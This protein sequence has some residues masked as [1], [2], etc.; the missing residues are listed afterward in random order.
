MENQ[1]QT[2]KAKSDRLGVRLND[3]P[4][5]G[6]EALGAIFQ[7]GAVKY[8][9]GNWKG[10]LGD[11]TYQEERLNHAIRHLMLWA[12]GDRSE[13]HLAKVAWFC[14]TQIWLEK[15]E[16]RQ[17]SKRIGDFISNHP[18]GSTPPQGLAGE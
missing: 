5:E 16:K 12:N 2:Q 11:K 8:G 1:N 6:L 15:E 14:V 17:I 13:A 4:Y 9:V 7:E 18:K 3:I 10:G